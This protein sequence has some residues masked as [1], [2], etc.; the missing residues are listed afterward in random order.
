MTDP[1]LLYTGAAARALDREAIRE[2]GVPGQALM[3]LAGAAVARA[4]A[5]ACGK[6]ATVVILAGAG[7]NGGDGYVAARWLQGWGHSVR[8]L[9]MA[10][11]QRLRGDAAW[12]Y[13]TWLAVGGK[14]QQVDAGANG[15]TRQ[16]RALLRNADVVVDAVLG[17]GLTG[18]VREPLATCLRAVAHVVADTGAYVLAVDVPSGIVAEDGTVPGVA[19]RADATLTM[20]V[21]KLALHV[22]PAAAY[23]GKVE[24]VDLG[25]S[26]QRARV[27][28]AA[29]LLTPAC[30]RIHA[31]RDGHK[32][33]FGT[34]VCLAGSAA[35][36]G[37]PALVARGALR[38]GAGKVVVAAPAAA[39]ARLDAEVVGRPLDEWA[40]VDAT[41]I[42]AVLG[43]ADAVVCGPG[44]GEGAVAASVACAAVATAKPIVLDADALQPELLSLPLGGHV[45]LT[46]HPG[47]A[48]RLLRTSASRVQAGRVAAVRELAARTQAVV[49]L[50]G[51]GT[52]I[53]QGQ[54]L[55]VSPWAT[56]ALAVPGSG[57][58]LAGAI[59]AR[60]AAGEEPF[61]AACAAV[62]L[63]GAAGASL[64]LRGNLAREVADCMAQVAVQGG[65]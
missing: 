36:P 22:W 30:A 24:V 15:V 57:D 1:H 8:V 43:D 7:N 60:M 14:V 18:P 5:A 65:V 59:A 29:Q 58:V 16:L 64:P 2:V 33:S 49:V 11:P 20:G 19:L 63:H 31:P 51:A 28:P 48:A 13:K 25:F 37:A 27:E 23:A 10:D 56:P 47:E 42:E 38:L 17:T 53:A 54:H 21:D 34:V 44:M 41:Q 12:A 52:L 3:E 4:A 40:K 62:W 50:K 61:A 26:P 46:P 55:A 35:M 32:G 45:V 9:A 6:G 39:L